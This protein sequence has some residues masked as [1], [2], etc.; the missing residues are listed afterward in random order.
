MS[1]AR[2]KESCTWERVVY[3]YLPMF[4]QQN[5]GLYSLSLFRK[6]LSNSSQAI[7][8]ETLF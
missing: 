5:T 7:K 6:R 8:L 1:R 2:K 4:Y 3:M